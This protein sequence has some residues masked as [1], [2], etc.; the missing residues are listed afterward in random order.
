VTLFEGVEE[1]QNTMAEKRLV[2]IKYK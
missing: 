1:P 2:S